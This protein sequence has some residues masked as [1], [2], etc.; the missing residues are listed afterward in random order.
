M[1]TSISPAKLQELVNL[2]IKACR[3]YQS[4]T[5]TDPDFIK[6]IS[7]ISKSKR[8]THRDSLK[9]QLLELFTYI[10]VSKTN[11]DLVTKY[12]LNLEKTLKS[13]AELIPSVSSTETYHFNLSR[14]NDIVKFIGNLP[15]SYDKIDFNMQGCTG[16]NLDRIS[17]SFAQTIN[18]R[19]ALIMTDIAAY[20]EIEHPPKFSIPDLVDKLADALSNPKESG[21][22]S[23]Y[24]NED[25]LLCIFEA[26]AKDS[27]QKS[28]DYIDVL[29]RKINEVGRGNNQK[30]GL[31][32]W[33]AT[34]QIHN[35]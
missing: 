30:T 18:K 9:E 20:V 23:I 27:S 28:K 15:V 33:I 17:F 21:F 32:K 16:L 10:K 25:A 7:N 26:L 6:N 29:L 12:W 11:V 19:A 13:A 35:S 22:V 24:K 8:L 1:I 4:K 14:Y 34:Y 2:T 5:G 31:G 3:T